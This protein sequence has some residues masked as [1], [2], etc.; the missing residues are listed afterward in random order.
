MKNGRPHKITGSATGL[1][2][3]PHERHSVRLMFTIASPFF[4]LAR[5]SGQ[6][7]TVALHRPDPSRQARQFRRHDPQRKK[8]ISEQELAKYVVSAGVPVVEISS[9]RKDLEI[10][11]VMEDN[12]AIGRLG[13][14][15]LLERNFKN[16]AWAAAQ[17]FTVRAA[18]KD[19]IENS[20]TFFQK[21]CAM[22]N[23]IDC[24]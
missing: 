8:A 17:F 6:V 20:E 10:P 2:A 18:Q 22:G 16:F 14:E 7:I 23:K 3:L 12:E 9:V 4:A 21:L 15:H 13:A 11:C 1:S 19:P 5:R 24:I